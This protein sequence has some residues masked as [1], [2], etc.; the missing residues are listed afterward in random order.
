MLKKFVNF[1]QSQDSIIFWSTCISILF[2]L[3]IIGLWAYFYPQLPDKLP[4]FYTLPWGDK[5]LVSLSQF[6]ILPGINFLIILI[7]M[8]ISWHLHKSQL[9]LKKMLSLN[10]LTISILLLLT[11]I[12]I[13][14]TFI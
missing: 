5:Q 12:K 1:Y 13:I 10:S 4:L 6:L 7:N 2:T 11:A 9:L 14:Y 8:I 3:L